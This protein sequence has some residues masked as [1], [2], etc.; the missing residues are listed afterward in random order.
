MTPEIA[1]CPV[2]NHRSRDCKKLGQ[3]RDILSFECEGCG[4]FD[5]GE[6]VFLHCLHKDARERPLTP[7]QRAALSHWLRTNTADRTMP[8]CITVEWVLQFAQNAKLPSQAAQ[9]AN[10]IALIG[11]SVSANGEGL[12]L[13][14]RTHGSLIGAFDNI[15]LQQLTDELVKHDLV[16]RLQEAIIRQSP[17]GSDKGFR[18]GLTLQDVSATRRR[19]AAVSPA[20]TASWLCSSKIRS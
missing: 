7:M 14:D 18:Y 5:V 10:L 16:S 1:I 6:L 8:F 12:L 19:S 3:T 9:A 20:I 11:D 17:G 2:C 15:M 13:D 4:R